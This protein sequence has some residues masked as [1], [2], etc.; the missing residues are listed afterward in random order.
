MLV[1]SF[2]GGFFS[3]LN[4][5]INGTTTISWKVRPGFSSWLR[6]LPPWLDS[7]WGAPD[8]FRGVVVHTS[9]ID[10]QRRIAPVAIQTNDTAMYCRVY[11]PWETTCLPHFGDKQFLGDYDPYFQ[12]L[13]PT[14]FH[15]FLGSKA[16]LIDPIKNHPFH[17]G[18][19][20]HSH[21][22]AMNREIVHFLV[23][24]MMKVWYIKPREF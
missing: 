7:L 22:D 15:G 12:G 21:S 20:T 17:V 23:Q 9:H 10:H 24:G 13:K 19:C 2:T 1:V 8:H 5:L 14:F 11:L 3:P 6:Y 4:G 18:K 16:L